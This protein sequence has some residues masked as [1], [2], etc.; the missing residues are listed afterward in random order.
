MVTRVPS[1][2]EGGG[3][4]FCSPG[5]V[6]AGFREIFEGGTWSQPGRNYRVPRETEVSYE[7]VN[8]D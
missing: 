3:G 6:R 7:V 1:L 5:E 8:V 4:R 2:F